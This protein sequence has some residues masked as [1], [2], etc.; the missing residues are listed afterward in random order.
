MMLAAAG[1][2]AGITGCAG[3]HAP[4]QT[5]KSP[6]NATKTANAAPKESSLGT[7]EQEL[8][9][10]AIAQRDAQKQWCDYLQDLY[11]RAVEDET[12]WPS[13]D[14]CLQV[15]TPA[16]P[17]MLK[18]T[19]ECSKRALSKYEGDPFTAAYA[20]EVSRCGTEVLDA[21]AISHADLA[22]YVAAICG[23]A[24]ACGQ[25]AFDDCREALEAG[26][27]S[28]LER[29]IGAINN[30]GRAELRACLKTVPCQELGSQITSCLEPIMDRLLWLPG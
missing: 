7:S 16:S 28:N 6:T 25:L 11:L 21:V 4:A 12:T 17:K 15:M 2:L 22:P 30:S 18:K 8:E 3:S 5:A 26:L 19:A 27:G 23:R 1:A 24:V 14:Q 9:E 13:Y 20:A 10:E 29:A